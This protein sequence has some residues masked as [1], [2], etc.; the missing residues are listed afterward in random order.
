VE[1]ERLYF[2]TAVPAVIRTM[3]FIMGTFKNSCCVELTGVIAAAALLEGVVKAP[4]ARIGI[5]ISGGNVGLAQISQL[6]EAT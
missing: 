5:I 6:L 2:I 4:A 1:A 3:L